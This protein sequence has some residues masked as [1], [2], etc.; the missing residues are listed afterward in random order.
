MQLQ[1]L[2][3]VLHLQAQ[4]PTFKHHVI[5]EETMIPCAA[6]CGLRLPYPTSRVFHKF[7]VGRHTKDLAPVIQR[8]FTST[9]DHCGSWKALGTVSPPL[10][11]RNQVA[12]VKIYDELNQGQIRVVELHRALLET[13]PIE[14]AL[15]CLSLADR[16]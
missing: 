2:P 14:C 8:H 16:S 5:H 12:A 6:R 9:L 13:D 11:N 3:F 4:I 1:R 15:R 10:E 7:A